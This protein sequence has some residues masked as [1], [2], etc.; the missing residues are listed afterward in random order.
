MTCSNTISYKP[1]SHL[2]SPGS[3]SPVHPELVRR[4]HGHRRAG[5]G[6]GTIAVRPAGFARLAEGLWLFTIGLF[7]L[8]SA[9]YA[10]RWVLFFDEARRIFGH[11]TVSMFF[12]TIPMGLATILNG[13][14]LFGLPRW[15]GCD[16]LAE[17]LWW[18]DVAMSL[19]C[20]VLI[21][22]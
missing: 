7:L 9:L 16:A 14:L 15:G 10:A 8:F 2:Q 1:F 22:T 6:P 17:L 11:S 13:F 21:P 19:A 4:D 18:L 12:G 20:G 3:D 5:A